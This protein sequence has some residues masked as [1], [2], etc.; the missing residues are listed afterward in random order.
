MSEEEK[1]L[2]EKLKEAMPLSSKQKELFKKL[3]K[4]SK[5]HEVDY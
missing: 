5:Q 3:I 2:L 1:D 4:D